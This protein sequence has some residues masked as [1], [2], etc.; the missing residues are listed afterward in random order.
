VNGKGVSE[1]DNYVFPPDVEIETSGT[2]VFKGSKAP[3]HEGTFEFRYH[4]DGKYKV[5][6][7]SA[8]F[9]IL[10][11]LEFCCCKIER[12]QED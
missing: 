12:L 11:K 2:I 8:P 5:L 3:W 9:E 7:K 10:G 1:S 4:E 6:A